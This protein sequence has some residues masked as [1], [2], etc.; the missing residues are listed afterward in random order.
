MIHQK[1]LRATDCCIRAWCVGALWKH[2]NKMSRRDTCFLVLKGC[3]NIPPT[4]PFS[5]HV[6]LLE[7]LYTN[8]MEYLCDTIKKQKCILFPSIYRQFKKDPQLIK[9][10]FTPQYLKAV[11]VTTIFPLLLL[12]VTRRRK[13]Q[14]F[15]A[16]KMAAQ[17]LF[18]LLL[19][20]LYI[21]QWQIFN[22]K[23]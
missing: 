5:Q 9:K 23:H 1:V 15:N 8:F 10:A 2:M 3:Q 14:L 20:K 12:W 17:E 16:Q 13:S 19:Q 4:F 21:K 11:R 6:S 7:L 22:I 18:P